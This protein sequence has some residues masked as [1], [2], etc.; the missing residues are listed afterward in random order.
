VFSWANDE[1]VEV[2]QMSVAV[3]LVAVEHDIVQ[4][5]VTSVL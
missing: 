2:K 1:I 3:E 5:V 4:Q